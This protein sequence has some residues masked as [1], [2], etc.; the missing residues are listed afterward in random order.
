M[1]LLGY[2][3]TTLTLIAQDKNTCIFLVKGSG[4]YAHTKHVNNR[5]HQVRE[6]AARDKPEV[7]LYKI[8]E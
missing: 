2:E 6:F 1:E 4:V 7:K 5:F 3:Q 8:T